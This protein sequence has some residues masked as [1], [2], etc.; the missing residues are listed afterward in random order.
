MKFRRWITMFCSSLVLAAILLGGFNYV[1]DPFGV[2][3]DKVLKWY[4]Y[5]MVNNPRVSKIA[6]LDQFHDRYDSY[7]IGGSKSSSISPALLNDYYG[8]ASFYSM[9][10]YGGDFHDYEK[11]LYYIVD[12]YKPKNIVIHMSLQEIGHFHETRSEIKKSLHAKVLNEPLIP[13]YLKYL[14]L[15]PTY[16][17]EKL[18]G[19]AKRAIDSFEYS[20]IIPESGVYNKVR[21]D[22]EDL[23]DL[24]K[25]LEVNPQFKAGFGP[26]TS[27]ALDKNVDALRRMK[28]YCEARNIS[29]RLITGATYQLEMKSYKL[30]DL[31][32]YWA[33]IAEVTDFWDFTGFTPVSN[34]PRNFY[35][36]MHYRNHV[37]NM[38]L[39]YIFKDPDVEVPEGFGHYTTK[40]NV[41]EHAEKVFTRPK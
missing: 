14:T 23:S 12:N 36:V 22:A 31:K 32:T 6:Y 11:T 30:D 10:M 13:F 26:I 9:L 1:V 5:D 15:N 4:S 24:D 16:G 37:G 27:E 8:G 33:K 21:R 19:Y 17:Y 2:F 18:E 39:G 34:D 28:E 29:F 20:Q 3:G 40:E 41:V 35:D 7:V 25:Y 38:M